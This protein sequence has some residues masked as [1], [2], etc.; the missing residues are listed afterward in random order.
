ML[1]KHDIVTSGFYEPPSGLKV[2]TKVIRFVYLV[3][4]L[5]VFLSVSFL[6]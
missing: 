6:R 5:L 1:H 2:G 4:Y 3:H